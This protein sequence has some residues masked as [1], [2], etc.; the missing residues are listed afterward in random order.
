MSRIRVLIVDDSA[1]I[2]KVLTEIL[3]SDPDIEVVGTANDPLIARDKIKLLSPDVITLDV[4]MPNMD[5]I[6]FLKNLMRL[7]PMPVVMISTLTD[8]GASV[9]LQALELGAVDY[10]SKPKM[11]VNVAIKDYSD[12][13]IEK[14]KMAS[15]VSRDLLA[16]KYE[17]ASELAKTDQQA[18]EHAISELQSGGKFLNTTD[19]IIAIGSS[20]G[21]TEAVKQVLLGLPP[22]VAGIVVAQH[23]PVT[24]SGPFA[25]RMN[26]TTNL[27]VAEAKNGDLIMPG[28]VYIAPGDKHLL[29]RKSGAKYYC[30]LEDG[31]EV[32]RHKPSVEVL[33]NSVAQCAGPNAMGIML[34]GMGAD[35]AKGMLEMKQHGSFNVAQD[36][37]TSVVWG[38][39]GAAVKLDA[40]E[41]VVP[42]NK[43]ADEII[44]YCQ[45]S[46]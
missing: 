13:I 20:T 22:N 38:M 17:M 21:G 7:R 33:F 46:S 2:R 8:A 28:R 10:I 27:T 1:L 23:I 34:T 29:V 43:V 44:K 25:Q 42:L 40:V 35:G 16:K 18:T 3:S 24:F 37:K 30:K 11:D 39:P 15:Q 31:P 4:E 9:T 45:R 14:V 41:K 5:G 32:N 26:D 36:E 19:K 12:E 6:T